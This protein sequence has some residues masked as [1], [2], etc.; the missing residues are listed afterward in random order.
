MVAQLHSS[1]GKER[2][3]GFLALYVGKRGG[4]N[5]ARSVPRKLSLDSAPQSNLSG[6]QHARTD[7]YGTGRSEWR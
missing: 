5:E 6:G 4:H 1:V 7:R 3:I 2:A